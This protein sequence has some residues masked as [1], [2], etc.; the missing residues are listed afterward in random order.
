MAAAVEGLCKVEHTEAA[1]RYVCN[2]WIET[3]EKNT[4]AAAQL[5]EDLEARA[6]IRYSKR[7]RCIFLI[8]IIV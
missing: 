8:A 5:T 2:P 7:A 4:R 1:A 6:A 3:T